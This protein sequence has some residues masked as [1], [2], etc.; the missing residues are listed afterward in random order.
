MTI[1]ELGKIKGYDH[2][3]PLFSGPPFKDADRYQAIVDFWKAGKVMRGGRPWWS[4]TGTPTHFYGP[5]EARSDLEAYQSKFAAG[6]AGR[7]KTLPASASFMADFY[8]TERVDNYAASSLGGNPDQTDEYGRHFAGKSSSL[9]DTALAIGSLVAPFIPGWGPALAAAIAL[10]QGKSLDDAALAAIKSYIPG[11]PMA[12]I[13]FDFGVAVAM[14]TPV[15]K[16]AVDAAVKAT[17]EG[18]LAYALARTAMGDGLDA[19]AVQYLKE[20]YPQ[21]AALIQQNPQAWLAKEPGGK[22]AI[23]KGAAAQPVKLTPVQLNAALLRAQKTPMR[24]VLFPVYTL[25]PVLRAHRPIVP[26]SERS[27]LVAGATVGLVPVGVLVAREL[28]R[29]VAARGW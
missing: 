7:R 2:G 18:A 1:G 27:W 15:D 29:L 9:V 25:D 26:E 14:G 13:A 3:R 12:G 8:G 24:L 20:R 6:F 10:A 16:A 19:A 17:P 23:A 28:A 22:E 5:S 4:P 21:E 11:G